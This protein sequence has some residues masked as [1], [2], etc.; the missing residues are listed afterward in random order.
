MQKLNYCDEDIRVVL[1]RGKVAPRSILEASG[2][3]SEP[4][5]R[6]SKRSR[7][8]LASNSINLK[9]SGS[10]SMYQLK[11]MIWESFGVCLFLIALLPVWYLILLL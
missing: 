4:D 1:V 2:S 9:V 7:K 8:S 6:T 5:R 11:M 3:I 10:T